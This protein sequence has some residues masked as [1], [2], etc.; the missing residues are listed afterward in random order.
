MKICVLSGSPAGKNSITLQTVLYL[1]KKFPEDSFEII[2]AGS[3]I[4]SLEKDMSAALKQ[5]KSSEL[6]LFCYPVYTFLVPSQLHRFIELMKTS[7]I[8][9][10][11]KYAAQF[12]TSKHFYDTTAHNFIEENCADMGLRYAGGLSA[13]MED[14][15]R[16]E[17]REDA[18]SFWKMVRWRVQ[19][20]ICRK[21]DLPESIP[22]N[23]YRRCLKE[24]I[25]HDGHDTVVV[26]NL[27]E[28]DTSL[29][30]MIA[31][32]AAAYPYRTRVVNIGEFPFKGGCLG[33]FHCASTGKCIYKDGF[34]DFLRN[35]IQSADAIVY[36]F[37]VTDHSMGSCMKM[38][39]DRQF[40]NGHRTVT[41]GKPV[42]Y[43]I[44][45]RLSQEPNLKLTIE[46]R[47]QVGGNFLAGCAQDGEGIRDLS[48]NL[49]YAVRYHVQK[50]A[51]FLGV[52][53]MKIF[54]D[55]IWVM[56][57]LMK[58]DHKFYKE[59]GFYDFPQ[60]RVGTI[61]L[62][63][64][65]GAAME[66]KTV[67]KKIGSKMTEGMLMPYRKVILSEQCS[68]CTGKASSRSSERKGRI[69]A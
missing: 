63:K 35:E 24:T 66:N 53:G 59:H 22:V 9:L 21:P 18:V 17:G 55:L 64:A 12:S 48:M 57:G 31:D 13:D 25:K 33:C 19:K 15:L 28:T 32:F 27:K 61:L 68:G 36:A 4:K 6:I 67:R 41:M 16:E 34:D 38:Y 60:K 26:A 58:A 20:G 65:A 47:A 8:D 2:Y 23:P 30:N 44:N 45:G 7:G 52:G 10:S 69:S 3:E 29:R 14:L 43:L 46:G 49:A 54:R 56:Q 37:T 1:E 62:M 39:D 51:M 11:D 40:C 5:I 50:P 42:G